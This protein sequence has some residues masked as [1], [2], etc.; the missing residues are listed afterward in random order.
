MMR[1]RTLRPKTS[2]SWRTS[3]PCCTV[4]LSGISRD[5][6]ALNIPD[7]SQ[8]LPQ[9]LGSLPTK[10]LLATTDHPHT[11]PP[12]PGHR[13]NGRSRAPPRRVA[14]AQARAAGAQAARAGRE[15][16]TRL[17]CDAARATFSSCLTPGRCSARASSMVEAAALRSA[18]AP[19]GSWRDRSAP[20]ASALGRVGELAGRRTTRQ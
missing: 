10:I 13:S 15:L 2:R 6:P 8:I 12:E 18:A 3:E 20:S 4:V 7:I 5:I 9:I 19:L 17:S 14:C 1:W 16:Y 11:K